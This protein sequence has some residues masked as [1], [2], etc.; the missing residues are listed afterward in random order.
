MRNLLIL[1]NPVLSIT[2][3]IKNRELLIQI[4]KRNILLRYK[5]SILGFIWSFIYP[6]MMLSIYTFVFGI[7]FK[8]RWGIESFEN[9]KAAFPLI[10]FCGM[11]VFNIFSESVNSSTS[12]IINN[13][14]YVK[15]VVFP[16]ELLP[17]CNVVT[18]FFFGF[19][20]F[21]LLFIGIACFFGKIFWTMLLFPITLLPLLLLSAGIS[22]FVASLGVYLRDIPQLVAIITQ[23]LFF[24]TPIFYPISVVP[25][26]LQWILH[27][28]P[29]SS[30]V[31]QTRQIFIYGQTPTL[32]ACLGTIAVSF[33]IF[34]LGFAWFMKTKKGFADVL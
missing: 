29:L 34:Q 31:E 1:L 19:A 21:I 5:G 33:I 2:T 17:M 6:L 23:M 15:K 32:T 7:V 3:V 12:V 22:F 13:Q 24:M 16:I 27:I 11:S 20:W 14:N 8:A 30:I 10:M 18:S 4:I 28:N 25:E 9:N 26:N